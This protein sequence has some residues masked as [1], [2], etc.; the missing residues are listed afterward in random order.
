MV[1]ATLAQAGERRERA[2]T[3]AQGQIAERLVMDRL[4]AALDPDYRI[5]PDVSWLGRTAVN[6]GLRDG[7]ADIV[8]AHPNRGFLSSPV[9]SHAMRMAAGTQ[10]SSSGYAVDP[11]TTKARSRRLAD[12][13]E[14]HQMATGLAMGSDHGHHDAEECRGN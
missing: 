6:R 7:E 3:Q 8:L 11:E 13:S 5:P 10:A 4:R 12:G 9:R 2:L 14:A 1:D